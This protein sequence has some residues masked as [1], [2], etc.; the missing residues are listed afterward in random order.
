MTYDNLTKKQLKALIKDRASPKPS[1]K[2]M[3]IAW[4]VLDDQAINEE[5]VQIVGEYGDEVIDEECNGDSVHD[6]NLTIKHLDKDLRCYFRNTCCQKKTCKYCK[7]LKQRYDDSC[8]KCHRTEGLYGSNVVDGL[9]CQ[10]CHAAE[11]LNEQKKVTKKVPP[12][13]SS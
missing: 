2:E 5:E 9:I 10:P 8:T 13:K 4:L 1:K 11:V 7:L 12:K 3:M 6:P